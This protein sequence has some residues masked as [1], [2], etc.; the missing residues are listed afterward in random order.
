MRR[1]VESSTTDG[2]P[3]SR[4]EHA[5]RACCDRPGDRI[6]RRA[7]EL[8]PLAG[9]R[10]AGLVILFGLVMITKPELQWKM[11]RRAY[12]NP[13]AREPSAKGLIAIGVSGALGVVIGIV[14]LILSINRQ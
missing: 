13:A 11:S 12:K 7:L 8:A 6:D 5:L 2:R 9:L 10:R 1:S 3:N 14:F 4:V